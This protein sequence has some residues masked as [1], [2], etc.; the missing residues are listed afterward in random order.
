MYFCKLND[1]VRI[2]RILRASGS[3]AAEGPVGRRRVQP[4]GRRPQAAP[5]RPAPGPGPARASRIL[6][7]TGTQATSPGRLATIIASSESESVVSPWP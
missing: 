4:E 6:V 7:F 5:A 1:I 3:A 2:A